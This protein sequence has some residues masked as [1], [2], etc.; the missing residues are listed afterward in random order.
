MGTVVA[1][2][3]DLAQQHHRMIFM[4]KVV[5]VQWKL[6][7]EIAKTKVNRG[8]DVIFKSQY[9][10]PASLDDSVIYR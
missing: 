9:I 3:V 7:G 10:L 5:A 2:V 6:S 8:L 1:G 4:N